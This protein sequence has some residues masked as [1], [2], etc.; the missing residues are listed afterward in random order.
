[1][2][3]LVK[4]RREDLNW[5]GGRIRVLHA[6][7]NKERLA[8]FHRDA[9]KAIHRYLGHR[10]DEYPELWVTEERKPLGYAG[11]SNDLKRV[12]KWAGVTVKDRTHAFRR[13]WAANALRAGTPRPHVQILGGW[14]NDAM[15]S[16]YTSWMETEVEEA[17][18][19]VK[20]IDPWQ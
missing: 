14:E 3:E 12:R 5:D 6:K 9:Q 13:T 20:D 7:G 17:L 4:L 15:V 19:A 2:N 11:M 8:P 10:T 16:L 18:L 1:M